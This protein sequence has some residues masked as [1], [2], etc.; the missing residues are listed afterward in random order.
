MR[1]WERER[2]VVVISGTQ[3]PVGRVRGVCCF[4]YSVCPFHH[5]SLL[6]LPFLSLSPP[7]HFSLTHPFHHDHRDPCLLS[8]SLSLLPEDLGIIGFMM[9]EWRR[10]EEEEEERSFLF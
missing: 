4:Y 1:R 8:L 3:D 2:G 6:P 5:L 9:K 7:S 10:K